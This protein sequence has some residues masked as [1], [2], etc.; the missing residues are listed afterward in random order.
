MRSSRSATA[1][2][3]LAV[4]TACGTA[5]PGG[6]TTAV[7]PT[8][9]RSS[10][11]EPAPTSTAEVDV[12]R[13]VGEPALVTAV[14]FAAH[15]TYDRVV[16]DIKGELPGYTVTWAQELVQDGSGKPIDVPG[17]AYL[18]VVL[19]PANAHTEQGKPTWAG[20]P[21]FLARLG[22]VRAVVRTG[23]FEGRVGVGIV[24]DRRAGFEVKEQHGP[25]RL[26]IDVAH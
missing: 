6:D 14:R 7:T 2:L 21:I 13:L 20:G 16:I 1:L 9:A 22:N 12:E 26:V 3:C 17:G 8:P 15:R 10:A 11:A 18:Q 4:L 23:D 24:L 25:N 19:H 5:R